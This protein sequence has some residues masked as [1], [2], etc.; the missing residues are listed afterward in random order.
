MNSRQTFLNGKGKSKIQK[1]EEMD[2]VEF[3][4]TIPRIEYR[5]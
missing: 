2:L 5:T 4:G 1:I 3:C